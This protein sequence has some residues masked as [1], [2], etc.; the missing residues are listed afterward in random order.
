M[1]NDVE[2]AEYLG[3]SLATVRKWRFL[4]KGPP[5]LKLEGSLVR[6]RKSEV[7][8]WLDSFSGGSTA[9]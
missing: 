6:Y 4:K 8:A 5:F 7:D 3:I 9:A 2:L 1:F